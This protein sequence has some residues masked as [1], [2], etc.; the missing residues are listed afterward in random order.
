MELV[1]AH[2]TYGSKAHLFV[3]QN[4]N[5]PTKHEVEQNPEAGS[6][7]NDHAVRLL[8]CPKVRPTGSGRFLFKV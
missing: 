2:Q 8:G 1:L 5:P 4:T 6:E 3:R 7:E